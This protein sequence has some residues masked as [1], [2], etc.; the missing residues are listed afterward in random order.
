MEFFNIYVIYMYV[1]DVNIIPVRGSNDYYMYNPR[2]LLA[3]Y[4]PSFTVYDTMYGI[5]YIL[6]L[7][8]YSYSVYTLS[9][10]KSM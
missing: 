9:E 2:D 10:Y 4:E 7:Y 6:H 3:L 8:M 1:N 5:L